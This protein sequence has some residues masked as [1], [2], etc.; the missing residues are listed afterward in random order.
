MILRIYTLSGDTRHNIK[1]F[2]ENAIK[3]AVVYLRN[4]FLCQSA[5]YVGRYSPVVK[6]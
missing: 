3:P 5:N 6:R 1:Y 4:S 2:L